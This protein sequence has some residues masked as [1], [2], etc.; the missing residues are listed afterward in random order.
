MEAE[1]IAVIEGEDEV[2]AE[3][4]VCD[5]EVSSECCDGVVEVEGEALDAAEGI[6]DEEAEVIVGD[7]EVASVARLVCGDRESVEALCSRCGELGVCGGEC[8]ECFAYKSG[9]DG[10]EVCDFSCDSS[11]GNWGCE[12]SDSECGVTHI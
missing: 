6:G 7:A 1:G 3:G 11:D 10:R 9:L 8:F 4:W 2:L 5:E 12:R